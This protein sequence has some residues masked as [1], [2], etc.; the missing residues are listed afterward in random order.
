MYWHLY[1]YYVEISEQFISF[2]SGKNMISILHAYRSS[3]SLV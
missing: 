2:L 1:S 3:L